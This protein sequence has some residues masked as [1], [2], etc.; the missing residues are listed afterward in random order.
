MERKGLLSAGI[1]RAVIW[2]PSPG[3]EE[4]ATTICNHPLFTMH[5]SVRVGGYWLV[6]PCGAV[7]Y[8]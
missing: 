5:I 7:C 1:R 4:G 8:E 2:R 3:S 6:T